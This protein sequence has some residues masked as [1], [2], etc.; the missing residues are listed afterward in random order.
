[1][2]ISARMAWSL[3]LLIRQLHAPLTIFL[4]ND[5]LFSVVHQTGVGF[6]F[7]YQVGDN[8]AVKL[9]T[10]VGRIC[11]F[12]EFGREGL[13]SR[14]IY[15]RDNETGEFW[16]V[17]WEPVKQYCSDYKCIH[18]MGYTIISNECNGIRAEF[19][20]FVPKGADPVELWTL[21]FKDISGKDRDL[22][23]FVY[24]QFSFKYKW[25]FNSYG[26][27]IFRNSCFN[28]ALNAVVAKKHP[29]ISPHGFQTGFITADVNIDAF[30]GS[31]DAFMG[32]YNG[33][34]EPQAVIDGRCTNTEGSSDSTVGVTQFDVRLAPDEE[35]K[36]NMILGI[37]DKTENITV[38]KDRYLDCMDDHFQALKSVNRDFSDLNRITTPDEHLNR[39]VNS[40]MKHQTAYGAKWCRWGWMGYRDIVQHGYGVSSFDPERCREILEEAFKYQYENGMAPARLESGGYQGLLRQRPLVGIRPCLLS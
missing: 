18:G 17:N 23:I 29:H 5:S 19:R 33:Y 35:R 16:N 36:I 37:T 28:T 39:M 15:V 8:E 34:N 12:D 4:W 38:L 27:M 22:S 20:I 40:W 3:L 2:D 13:M 25:D 7:D 26:D 1:M 6:F 10:G 9:L 24:N 11:D 31:R 32:I 21:D 14:L 30:D